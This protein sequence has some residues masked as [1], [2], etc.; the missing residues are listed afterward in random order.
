MGLQEMGFFG[1]FCAPLFNLLIAF[2]VNVLITF[3]KRGYEPFQSRFTFELFAAD[4]KMYFMILFIV[5]FSLFHA[6]LFGVIFKFA[7]YRLKKGL[8]WYLL[9]AYGLYIA[10]IVGIDFAIR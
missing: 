6:I 10:G 2:S 8:L 4:D 5:L 9:L 1:C 7:G 3:A